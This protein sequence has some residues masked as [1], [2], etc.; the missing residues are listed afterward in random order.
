MF[1]T[2]GKKRAG[3]INDKLLNAGKK[4]LGFLNPLLYSAWAGQPQIFQ[5]VTSG[6]NADFCCAGFNANPAGGWCPISGMGVPD[7]Q[8]LVGTIGK[9]LKVDL[10]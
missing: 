5:K 6:N 2:N 10:K 3:L 9:L 4:T 7:F 8:N 1:S